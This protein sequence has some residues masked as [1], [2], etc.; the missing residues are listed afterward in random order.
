MV[1]PEAYTRRANE[2]LT[3]GDV[4]SYENVVIPCKTEGRW[5]GSIS[6]HVDRLGVPFPRLS[7][8]G[9]QH[10]AHG[11]KNYIF[12]ATWDD[13]VRN[14]DD[15]IFECACSALLA[16]VHAHLKTLAMPLLGGN[17]GHRFVG[18]M[19]RA[20]DFVEDAIEP[21]GLLLPADIV[22]VTR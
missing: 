17:E 20:I 18:A 4:F 12:V 1:N 3:V 9:S 15:H 16:S 21:T 6:Q 19:E 10:V 13:H 5:Y 7:L 22:F 11:G 8:C 14:S 2:R